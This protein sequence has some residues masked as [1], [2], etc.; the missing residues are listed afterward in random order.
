MATLTPSDPYPPAPAI[1]PL[2]PLQMEDGNL[3]I[4]VGSYRLVVHASLMGRESSHFREIW[5][6]RPDKHSNSTVVRFPP[7]E[8]AHIIHFVNQLYQVDGH[9]S[10]GRPLPPEKVA[11][12]LFIGDKYKYERFFSTMANLV[13]GSFPHRLNSWDKLPNTLLH[14]DTARGVEFDLLPL[15]RKFGL[16]TALPT[17]YYRICQRYNL[18]QIKKGVR[19]TDGSTATLTLEDRV[20][21]CIGRALLANRA[22]KD[23]W[24]WLK[25]EYDNPECIAPTVCAR[26]RATIKRALFSVPLSSPHAHIETMTPWKIF[27]ESKLCACCGD[28]SR[29]L[30]RQGRSRTWANL[31]E[32]FGLGSWYALRDQELQPRKYDGYDVVYE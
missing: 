10:S 32:I 4:F 29:S 3:T 12:L 22:D 17:L 13:K 21:I 6:Q 31:P 28:Y 14:I 19:R 20:K 16:Q 24:S 23:A 27:W 18:R 8:A 25:P 15:V 9:F 7:E 2:H 30:H 11:S 26:A 5:A 1:L